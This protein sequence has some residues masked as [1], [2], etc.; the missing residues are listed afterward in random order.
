MRRR[1][2]TGRSSESAPI[3]P[4][5][6][7]A[8]RSRSRRFDAGGP[9]RSFTRRRPGPEAIMTRRVLALIVALI[10]AA[11]VIAP[12]VH[13]QAARKGRTIEILF[14]GHKSPHHDSARFEPMLASAIES[15]GFHFTYTPDPADLNA[16]NLY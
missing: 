7:A 13:G 3:S 15:E 16:A 2:S 10:A 1:P 12:R 9:R 8:R 14:L 6:R 11:S 4:R 5:S